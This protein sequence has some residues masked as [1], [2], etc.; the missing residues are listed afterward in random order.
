M[1]RAFL[2]GANGL[3]L[4]G[5]NP[6]ECHHSYG[7]DHTWSR[8][9]V[10]NKLLALC[11]VE[12]DRIAL[13]HSDITQP[14]Q[15]VKT[16]ASFLK[17][18]DRL[19]PIQRDPDTQSKLKALYDALHTYRVRWVLGVSLRRPWETTYPMH[20]PN[21]T[22]YDQTLTEILTEEFFRAGVTNLFR[23]RGRSLQLPDIAQALSVDEE[24]AYEYLKDMGHEG[25]ISI[26][27]INRNRY[28]GLPFG[29]Q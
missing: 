12:R 4:I 22:A 23:Q 5:C 26:V 19:G 7:L 14:D 16:V 29:I 17:T 28:Y 21:P 3:L 20:M 25:L 6:E 9:W 13:A 1:G 10:L 24:R 15:Y 8:V 11:G 2:E 27:F 18:M